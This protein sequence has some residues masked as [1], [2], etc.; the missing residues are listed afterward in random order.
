MTFY[1]LVGNA[2]STGIVITRIN[3]DAVIGNI[4]YEPSSATSGDVVA[5]IH[6][7]KEE[8]IVTNNSGS[9]TYTFTGND[10]FTFEFEDEYG[11]T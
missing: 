7:N 10:S 6:F 9:K 1:D 4:T 5:T 3:T 8:V 2:G 11:N